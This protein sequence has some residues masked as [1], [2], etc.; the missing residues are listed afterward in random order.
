MRQHLWGALDR[1]GGKRA[2]Q[3]FQTPCFCTSKRLCCALNADPSIP[4][5][6]SLPSAKS[7]VK[8]YLQVVCVPGDIFP[9]RGHRYYSGLS[10]SASHMSTQTLT[11]CPSTHIYEALACARPGEALGTLSSTTT[12][13]KRKFLPEAAPSREGARHRTDKHS[14]T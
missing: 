12:R 2:L 5:P 7:P 1:A 3:P 13:T 6:K 4:P 14:T 9:S 11:I 10:E 8:C